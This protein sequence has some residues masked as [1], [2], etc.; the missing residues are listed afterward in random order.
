MC[1]MH[2]KVWTI[3][4]TDPC[5]ITLQKMMTF[6]EFLLDSADQNGCIS[7]AVAEAVSRNHYVLGSFVEEYGIQR[8]WSMGV[9]AGEFLVWLGY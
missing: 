9:D 3:D 7:Y 4:Y 8:D 6:S 1:G 5:T 2:L